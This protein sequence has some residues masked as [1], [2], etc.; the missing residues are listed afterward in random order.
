M[1]SASKRHTAMFGLLDYFGDGGLQHANI[2]DH[3]VVSACTGS[4]ATSET[5]GS[6]PVQQA[7]EG[8]GKQCNRKAR[9]EAEENHTQACAGEA[10]EQDGLP[11]DV[12]AQLS[13]QDACGELGKGEGGG[14]Q[15]SVNCHL[16][17]VGGYVEVEN[18][19]VDV[20]E[21][22]HEGDGLA[23]PAEC[24]SR[25]SDVSLKVSLCQGCADL[26]RINSWRE[27][28]GVAGIVISS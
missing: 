6:I 21:D 19:V 27:G 20:R 18:H 15:A 12:I 9:S 28:K 5:Q 4:V 17:I 23:Y 11:A 26:P 1:N 3:A 22:G 14:D 7:A 8:S 10:G 16:A 24:F 13:P 2:A 25:A